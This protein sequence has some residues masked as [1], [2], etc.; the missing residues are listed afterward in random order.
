MFQLISWNMNKSSFGKSYS[1]RDM[2]ISTYACVKLHEELKV[3]EN[4]FNHSFNQTNASPWNK[5]D[6]N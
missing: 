2:R 6:V 5:L 4:F 3:S 1:N